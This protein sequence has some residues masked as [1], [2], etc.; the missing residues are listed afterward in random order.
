MMFCVETE[1]GGI[2]EV[3]N[4]YDQQ[5]KDTTD[6]EVATAIVVKLSQGG[7]VSLRVVGPTPVYRVH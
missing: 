7:Y 3:T 6:P 5:G 2:A 1:E 4:M